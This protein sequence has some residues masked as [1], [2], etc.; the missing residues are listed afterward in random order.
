MTETMTTTPALPDHRDDVARA[1]EWVAGLLA[2]VQRTQYGDATP[3][4]EFDVELLIKHLIAVADRLVVLGRGE[5]ADSVHRMA[6]EVPVD[7]VAAYRERMAAARETWADDAA[8]TRMVEVPWGQAPGAAVLGVYLSEHLTHG[9]DLAVATGQASEADPELAAKALR[10]VEPA[11]PPERRGSPVPF[12]P[13]VE[14]SPDAG[15]TE[16]LANFLGRT[17]S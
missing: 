11:V 12:G 14:P 7:L 13:V 5:P 1:Q 15:P 3:C 6:P 17:R 2:G 4:T 9:W 10:G 16:R 8:L